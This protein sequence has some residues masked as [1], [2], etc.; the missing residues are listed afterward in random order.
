MKPARRGVFPRMIILLVLSL[1]AGQGLAAALDEG[2]LQYFPNVERVRA[3]V[4]SAHRGSRPEEIDGRTAGQYL[5]LAEML[6][7]S[8][9]GKYGPSG[10]EQ[11]APAG[12]R[13]LREQYLQAP[14]K[15][16]MRA[17]GRRSKPSAPATRSP[18]RSPREPA[19]G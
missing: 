1:V 7:E 11:R 16:C 15:R 18:N 3:D 12:A 6:E 4:A 2:G 9:G 10:F 5:L 8:W 13:R 17:S 19:R 14:I